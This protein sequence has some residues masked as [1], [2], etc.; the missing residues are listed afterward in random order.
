MATVDFIKSQIKG[1]D[2]ITLNMDKLIEGA[3]QVY[4]KNS[5]T[6]NVKEAR[7]SANRTL[8]VLLAYGKADKLDNDQITI[9]QI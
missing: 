4:V 1:K 2:S 7:Y 8:E 5:G 3:N 6:D 9:H